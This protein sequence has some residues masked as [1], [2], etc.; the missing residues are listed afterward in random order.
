MAGLGAVARALQMVRSQNPEANLDPSYGAC[1][2]AIKRYTCHRINYDPRWCGLPPEE[3]Q[4][5][6]ALKQA[7]RR[8]RRV[9]GCASC[10]KRRSSS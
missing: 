1:L 2:E 8:S 4:T 3:I 9:Q 5:Q 10:G 7:G 6:A